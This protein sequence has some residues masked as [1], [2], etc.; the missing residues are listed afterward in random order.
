MARQGKAWRGKVWQDQPICPQGETMSMV[1]VPKQGSR[2]S[3]DTAQLLGERFTA[4]ATHGP[5]TAEQIIEDARPAHSTTQSCFEWDNDVAG[6]RYRLYQAQHYL[7]NIEIVRA[8]DKPPVRAFHVIVQEPLT[9]H[10]E[11]QRGFLAFD[12][13]RANSALWRQVVDDERRRLIATQRRLR[14]YEELSPV[15]DGPLQLAID[16]LAPEVVAV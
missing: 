8:D 15:A 9:E 12:T 3:T 1:F 11:P 14:L 13:V 2:I 6:D 5:L 4:L 7:R 10:G 16:A